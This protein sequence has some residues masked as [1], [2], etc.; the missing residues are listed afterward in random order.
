MILLANPSCLA[1]PQPRICLKP[2]D[3]CSPCIPRVFV[4]DL[5]PS[6][7][8]RWFLMEDAGNA[9]TPTLSRSV[10]IEVARTPGQLQHRALQ[11]QTLP[12]LL[13]RCEGDHLQQQAVEVCR[14]LSVSHRE[15]S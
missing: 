15:S 12:S 13:I 9:Q 3:L 11:D 8:W 2:H 5:V 4:T 7:S 1:K 6:A 14:V 10:A